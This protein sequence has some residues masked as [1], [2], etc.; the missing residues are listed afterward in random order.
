MDLNPKGRIPEN[1]VRR[2]FDVTARIRVDQDL[3][4][5]KLEL[6]GSPVN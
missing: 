1:V 6:N 2:L 3:M 5:G 4:N